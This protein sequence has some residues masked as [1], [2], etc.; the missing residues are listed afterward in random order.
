MRWGTEPYK[1]RFDYS[2]CWMCTWRCNIHCPYCP[3]P[4]TRAAGSGHGEFLQEEAPVDYREWVRAFDRLNG[5]AVVDISGGEPFLFRNLVPLIIETDRH[6][7]ALTTNLTAVTLDEVLAIP[8][9]KI[10]GITASFHFANGDPDGFNEKVVGIAAAGYPIQVNFVAWPKQIR[11]IPAL[12]D[13]FVRQHNIRFVIE[14]YSAG[15]GKPFPGYTA[16]E[17]EILGRYWVCDV[18]HNNE[19]RKVRQAILKREMP[20]PILCNA[21]NTRFMITPDGSVYP[22]NMIYFQVRKPIGNFLGDFTLGSGF[23]LC[24]L[25]CECGGDADKVL[26]RTVDE[27]GE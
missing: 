8:R 15:D 22:C 9:V 13:F 18:A 3:I 2:I 23:R 12:H 21:G 6:R 27:E 11:R 4:R 25:E 10:V 19:D 7:F 24:H 20:R 14:P 26:R 17:M 1:P 16:E 5:R